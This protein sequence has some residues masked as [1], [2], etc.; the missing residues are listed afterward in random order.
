MKAK[1]RLKERRRQPRFK[2]SGTVIALAGPQGVR[3]GK[4]TEIS[5]TSLSFQYH[6]TD[7]GPFSE[8]DIDIIWSDFVAAHHLKKLPVR[9]VS[10]VSLG[11]AER[12][13]H[14]TLRRTTVA[15]TDLSP[16]QESRLTR[17]I[18]SCGVGAC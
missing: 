14:P 10:D 8:Q 5:R 12:E 15:F 7:G 2:V 16:A 6:E 17:L 1:S 9:A 4:V 13:K 3:R 11:P 18:R